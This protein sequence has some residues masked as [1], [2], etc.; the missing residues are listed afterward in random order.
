VRIQ[1]ALAVIFCYGVKGGALDLGEYSFLPLVMSASTAKVCVGVF[2]VLHVTVAYVI[3]AQPLHE[4]MHA[5]IFPKTLHQTT[6]RGK[7]HW[8]GL[9]VGYMIYCLCLRHGWFDPIFW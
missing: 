6:F 7:A 1:Y 9:T 3:A 8:F 5:T 2:L 4:W